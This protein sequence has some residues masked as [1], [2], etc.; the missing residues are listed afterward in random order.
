MGQRPSFDVELPTHNQRANN[1]RTGRS[2]VAVRV[3][4][5]HS[6]HAR[7]IAWR[8]I[9]MVQIEGKATT[10]E[11]L[12]EVREIKEALAQVHGL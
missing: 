2:R 12:Q 7:G 1:E 10:D 11:V 9:A 8:L 3:S 5:A 4:N 6:L